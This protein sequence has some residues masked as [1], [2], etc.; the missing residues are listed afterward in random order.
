MEAQL[1]NPIVHSKDMIHEKVIDN[2]SCLCAVCNKQSHGK[3]SPRKIKKHFLKVNYK[4]LGERKRFTWLLN[5]LGKQSLTQDISLA[6]PDAVVFN[7]CRPLYLIQCTKDTIKYITSG[8]KL[9]LTEILKSYTKVV[10]NRKKEEKPGIKSTETYG[11]EIALLRYTMNNKENDNLDDTPE[12]ED[13]PLRVLSEKEF[14]DFMY[15]RAGS[16]IWKNIVYI[17]TI[18]KCKSGIANIITIIY[19]TPVVK[20]LVDLEKSLKHHNDESLM[21]SNPQ[22]YCELLC[23]RIDAFL[24]FNSSMEILQMKA[25]FSQDD[26]GKI[27]LTYTQELYIRHIIMPKK[28]SN[29]QGKLTQQELA[30]LNA[31]LDERIPKCIGKAKYEQYTALMQDIYKNAKNKADIDR[32]LQAKPISYANVELIQRLQTKNTWIKKPSKISSSKGEFDPR[33]VA[34]AKQ[35]FDL[36]KSYSKNDDFFP[37]NYMQRREWIFTPNKSPEPAPRNKSSFTIRATE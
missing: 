23:K 35:R 1:I 22:A 2:F 8:D 17:Q 12:V 9:G 25:E 29:E 27:W 24:H 6:T 3:I 15:E 26:L 16:V 32:V 14:F 5:E 36:M 10:R 11:K 13:G 7:K 21:F 30:A 34:R 31:E 33:N 18:V 19:N 20:N 37:T 4:E 28:L